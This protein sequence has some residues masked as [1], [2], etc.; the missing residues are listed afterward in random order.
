MA[1]AKQHETKLE[2]EIIDVSLLPYIFRVYTKKYTYI[3][4]TLRLYE[5]TRGP[6]KITGTPGIG[7]HFYGVALKRRKE[8]VMVE[9]ITGSMPFFNG[10]SEM[11]SS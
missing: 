7:E 3:K 8:K 2:A 10:E 6:L 9:T 11:G 5:I 1:E 4:C